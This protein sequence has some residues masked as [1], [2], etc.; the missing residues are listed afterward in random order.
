MKFVI[1]GGDQRFFTLIRKLHTDR[2]EIEVL[3]PNL[4][5]MRENNVYLQESEVKQSLSDLSLKNNIVILPIPT[6]RDNQ[7]LVSTYTNEIFLR[8]VFRA[9]NHNMPH[10]VI[11]YLNQTIEDYFF[12][13]N[14]PFINLEHR[15]DFSVFN[16]LLTVEGAINKTGE[17]LKSSLFRKKIMI[18]GYGRIAKLLARYLSVYG[19]DVT[20]VIRKLEGRVWAE[21]LGYKAVDF[22]K[23]YDILGEMEIIYNTVP[24]TVFKD[25][26]IEKF[27]E[28]ALYMELAALPGGIE[29]KEAYKDRYQY[30]E[31]MSV[32]AKFCPVSAGEVLYRTVVNIM[33]ERK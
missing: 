4:E 5:I 29:D 9:I 14:I 12:N 7:R 1:I 8:D 2:R 13:N 30:F 23:L 31:Y 18:T 24:W 3:A 6:T 21:V 22:S 20:L 27:K 17:I 19:A 15:E 25:E 10:V 11:G 16:A 28:N 33:E 32:P 26:H